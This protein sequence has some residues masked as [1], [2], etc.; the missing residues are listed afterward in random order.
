[1]NLIDLI[2]TGKENRI[3]TAM[4]RSITHLD[5][6]VIRREINQST[7]RGRTD[8]LR[9]RRI[10]L[11]GFPRPAGSHDQEDE[12]PDPQ[13]DQG[14]GR[15][16]KSAKKAD[17]RCTGVIIAGRYLPCRK[18]AVNGMGLSTL[19]MRRWTAARRVG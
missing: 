10:L 18:P 14:A 13:A 11:C 9:R 15:A 12:Q 3:S 5:P 2:P 17:E 8:L 19:R 4:L 1:M 16:E 7:V 6:A